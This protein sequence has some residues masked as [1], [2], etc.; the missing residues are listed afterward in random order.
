MTTWAILHEDG[1]TDPLDREDT[2]L[3]TALDIARDFRAVGMTVKF[4][5]VPVAIAAGGE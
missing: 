5:R 3:W 4:V 2:F 1:S